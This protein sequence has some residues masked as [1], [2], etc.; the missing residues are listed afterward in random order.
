MSSESADSIRVITTI[1]QIQAL[2]HPIRQEVLRELSSGPMTNKQLASSLDIAPG[3][4]HFHVKELVKAG[5]IELVQEIPRGG[6][7][8]KYYRSTAMSFRLDFILD[9]SDNAPKT[10]ID[11]LLD[12]A[13]H[14]FVRAASAAGGMPKD[15]ELL[16]QES[17]LSREQA[18]EVRRIL[19]S[20]LEKM[21][22]EA[23]GPSDDDSRHRY[24][25]TGVFHMGPDRSGEAGPS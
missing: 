12:S 15:T 23:Q 13:R 14:A 22:S 9:P 1:E 18:A 3:R 5:L 19:Q 20:L 6:V 17:M 11:A 10:L 8:E 4:L 21:R 16:Q 25:F 24:T 2:A 7:V